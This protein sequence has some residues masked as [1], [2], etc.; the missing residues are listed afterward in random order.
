MRCYQL[1]LLMSL[2]TLPSNG[3]R[4]PSNGTLTPLVA[5]ATHRRLSVNFGEIAKLVASDAAANDYFGNSVAIDGNTVVVGAYGGEAAY[6]YRTTNGGATYDQVA[7]L[8]ADDLSL[9]HI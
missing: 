3:L 6:V 8:T 7:K 4:E 9:I 2:P 5:R 1:C